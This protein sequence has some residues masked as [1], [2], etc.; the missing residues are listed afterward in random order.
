MKRL[1]MT[2]AALALLTTTAQAQVPSNGEDTLACRTARGEFS[3]GE[4]KGVSPYIL[5]QIRRGCEAPSRCTGILRRNQ[6]RGGNRA[7]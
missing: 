1:M 5:E 4:L 7:R 2:A 3:A 6:A